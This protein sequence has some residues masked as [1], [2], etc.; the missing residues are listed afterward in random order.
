[1]TDF[2][3]TVIRSECARM[4]L[5]SLSS[6][7]SLGRFDISTLSMPYPLWARLMRELFP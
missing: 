2:F 6:A 5:I 7:S 4:T 1:L 3:V